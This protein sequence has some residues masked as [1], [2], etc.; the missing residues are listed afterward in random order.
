MI[1]DTTKTMRSTLESKLDGATSLAHI[2]TQTAR[3]RKREREP[4]AEELWT[5][6][7]TQALVS[8]LPRVSPSNVPRACGSQCGA[9][10]PVKAGTR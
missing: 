9:P 6:A 4:L 5:L 7:V 8:E 10:S 3:E 2:D 1:G